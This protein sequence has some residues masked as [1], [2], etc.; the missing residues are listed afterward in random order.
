M[1]AA[2]GYDTALL[3][4]A[5]VR[6]AKGRLEDKAALRAALEAASFKSVRGAFRFNR[7]H[8][9]IQTIYLRQ[10]VK[11]SQGRIGNKLVGPLLTDHADAYAA[12]C[13]MK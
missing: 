5:A 7:N 11:D 8:Y 4:D 10:V 12:Q 1:Y 9:P 13:K 2:Q 3:L 6:D